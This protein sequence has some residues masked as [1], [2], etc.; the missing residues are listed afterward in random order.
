MKER[1]RACVVLIAAI[2]KRRVQKCCLLC[3]ICGTAVS[4]MYFA[5]EY[6]Y[7]S[8]ITVRVFMLQIFLK[9]TE[10]FVPVKHLRLYENTASEEV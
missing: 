7:L 2:C 3:Y 1:E 6:K 8:I 10:S 4:L 9:D 5:R